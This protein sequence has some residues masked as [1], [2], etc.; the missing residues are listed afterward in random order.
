[1]NIEIKDEIL[2]GEP[3]YRIRDNNGNILQDNI[4]IEKTTPV[5]QEATPINKKLFQDLYNDISPVGNIKL[6]SDMKDRPKALLCDGS[7]VFASDYPHLRDKLKGYDLYKAKSVGEAGLH[8]STFQN[9]FY[10]NGY[11]IT[12]YST[13]L[14]YSENGLDW[15]ST[16][17]PDSF[18]NISG[19]NG[20]FFATGDSYYYV[21][22][23]TDLIN[24]TRLTRPNSAEGI[25]AQKILYKN[26]I[27]IIGGE[28]GYLYYSLDKGKTWTTFQ[29]DSGSSYNCGFIGYV[30]NK[31]IVQTYTTSSTNKYYTYTSA[32]GVSWEMVEASFS[33]RHASNDDNY[34]YVI[35]SATAGVL[36]RSTDGI[37][38]ESFNVPTNYRNICIVKGGIYVLPSSSSSFFLYS[39]NLVD[40]ENLEYEAETSVNFYAHDEEKIIV[41]VSSYVNVYYL[42]G[43]ERKMI[44][45]T[46]KD[47]TN[48]VYGYINSEE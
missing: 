4:A 20:E 38:F 33:L 44:L 3:R 46:K 41:L 30:Q 32:D 39:S 26:G 37:N 2:T 1:M 47:E 27:V 21:Y 42:D 18:L 34:I 11:F 9:A 12:T 15:S 24:W 8:S 29:S 31:F 7:S 14:Y 40:W 23:S 16:T 6:Y 13:T 10:A 45:P 22:Y 28:Y 36:Y 17:I 48:Q 19:E 35:P 43:H 25:Y 5:K